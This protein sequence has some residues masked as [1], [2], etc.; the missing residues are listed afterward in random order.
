MFK[1]QQENHYGQNRTREGK[2][3]GSCP[4]QGLLVATEGR[5]KWKQGD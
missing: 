3:E 4:F 2:V 5:Q 1:K